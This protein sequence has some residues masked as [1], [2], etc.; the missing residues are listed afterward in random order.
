M[1]DFQLDTDGDIKLVNGDLVWVTG[2]DAIRQAIEFELRVALGECVY[3]TNRGTPWIQILLQIETP[4]EAR[5]YI[6]TQIVRRVPGVIDVG[7]IE[8][9]TN[10]QT[11][12]ATVSG[13][14]TTTQGPITFNTD[15]TAKDA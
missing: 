8:W 2:A 15:G 6:L 3:A 4:D 1:A 12:I 5:K 14:A 10:G 13:T 11:R 9:T 7:S